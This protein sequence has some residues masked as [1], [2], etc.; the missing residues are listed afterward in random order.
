TG[1][2][3]DP[4][5]GQ[6]HSYPVAINVQ[7]GDV[8]GVYVPNWWAGLALPPATGGPHVQG[9]LKPDPSVGQTVTLTTSFTGGAPL[10]EAATF[11]P[12]VDSDLA[13]GQP[14]DVTVNATSPAGAVVTY[15][16]PAA[17][18]ESSTGVSVSCL[19]ASGST[20]A[21]GDTTVTCTATDTDGD[22]N[23]PV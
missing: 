6:S 21:I 15:T 14:S 12:P 4:C 22:T 1:T 7:A 16:K 19:P 11:V 18:D 17:S 8:L 3:A 13:L 5:D 20:F 10:D 23:G 9:T 2:E